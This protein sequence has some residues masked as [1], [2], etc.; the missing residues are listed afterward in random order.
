MCTREFAELGQ[1]DLAGGLQTSIES[2]YNVYSVTNLINAA[3]EY[4]SML[5]TL[6]PGTIDYLVYSQLLTYVQAEISATVGI[7]AQMFT[8]WAPF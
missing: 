3:T 2:M 8:F 7:A 4:S 1:L 6:T 5:S